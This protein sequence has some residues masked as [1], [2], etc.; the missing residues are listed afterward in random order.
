[1]ADTRLPRRR[2]HKNAAIEITDEEIADALR[3]S[4]GLVSFASKMLGFSTGQIRRRVYASPELTQ[5]MT[6]AREDIIDQAEHS[7]KR[8][9]IA[10]EAWAVQLVLKSIGR[11]RGYSESFEL[12]LTDHVIN[13]SIKKE[14]DNGEK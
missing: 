8:A 7:L 3:K 6:D 4:N 9:V 11:V 10:G 5:I 12:T 2:V 14:Q 1:M 13:V